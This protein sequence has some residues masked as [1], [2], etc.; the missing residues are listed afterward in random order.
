MSVGAHWEAGETEEEEEMND[1]KYQWSAKAAFSVVKS[2]QR[3][4]VAQEKKCCYDEVKL[5]IWHQIR[6][7]MHKHKPTPTR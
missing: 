4:P 5:K 3:L 2:S 1:L 6:P 7:L